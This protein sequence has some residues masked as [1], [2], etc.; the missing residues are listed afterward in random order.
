MGFSG[1]LFFKP[2][3]IASPNNLP[4]YFMLGRE[5]L[6]WVVL[7][8]S[9]HHS[10]NQFIDWVHR[11]R[12]RTL[13]PRSTSAIRGPSPEHTSST[14]ENVFHPECPNKRTSNWCT[15]VDLQK[16]KGGS[17]AVIYRN[18]SESKQTRTLLSQPP[19]STLVGG[20]RRRYQITSDDNL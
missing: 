5:Y 10:L 19:G 20:R 12:S 14:V 1:L 2:L 3:K 4:C 16:G 11:L 9:D 6:K 15:L 17:N 18:R 13:T 7:N 8:K